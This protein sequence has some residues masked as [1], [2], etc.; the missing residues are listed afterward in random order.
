MDLMP[1]VSGVIDRRI[2]INFR[3]EPEAAR[4]VLPSRFEPVVI[5]GWAIGGVCLIRL[6]ALRPSVLPF[7]VGL[8]SENAAHRFAA[9]WTD[10]D[11]HGQEGVYIPRRDTDSRVSVLAGG[12]LF[13]GAHHL[14]QFDIDESPSSLQVSMTSR[15]GEQRIEVHADI[16]DDLPEDSVFTS[17][18]A[19]SKFHERGS[20]GYSNPRSGEDLEGIELRTHSW[21]VEPLKVRRVRSSYF[22]DPDRFPTGT[23]QFDHALL[24]RDIEHE[25]HSR[26]PLRAC[27]PA[28]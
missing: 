3:V 8:G 1:A 26:S 24:M 23:V 12:R 19:A 25:W 11:G 22:E 6:K 27:G 16:S 28:N 4:R 15:D 20:V 17:V 14:A 21:T 13:P 5:G 7:T 2:L 18:A 9:T 10:N